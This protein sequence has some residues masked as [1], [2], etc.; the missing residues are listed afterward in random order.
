M[1]KSIKVAFILTLLLAQGQGRGQADPKEWPPLNSR[2]VPQ[3]VKTIVVKE[4]KKME[5]RLQFFEVYKNKE[6]GRKEIKIHFIFSN[7]DDRGKKIKRKRMPKK[8]FFAITLNEESVPLDERNPKAYYPLDKLK[9]KFEQ[10]ERK[11]FYILRPGMSK[12]GFIRFPMIPVKE[13]DSFNLYLGDKRFS[14]LQ[15]A[16]RPAKSQEEKP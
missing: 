7:P 5:V 6:S 10:D 8:E 13:G 3:E 9:V 1:R 12:K 15:F 14:N 11:I 2:H 16:K 4:L